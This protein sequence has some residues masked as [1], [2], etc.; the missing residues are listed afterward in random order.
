MTD[1]LLHA[2][3]FL[4]LFYKRTVQPGQDL[5]FFVT[6]SWVLFHAV[7]IYYKKRKQLSRKE[8]KGDVGLGFDNCRDFIRNSNPREVYPKDGPKYASIG[9]RLTK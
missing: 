6:S 4:C 3:S 8:M 5:N 1:S 9:L 2:Y 7:S